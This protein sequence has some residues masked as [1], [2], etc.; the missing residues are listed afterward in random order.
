M[1]W[2]VQKIYAA[3][4]LPFT[5]VTS[6]E[7]LSGE[8][9]AEIRKRI[10]AV[11]KEEAPVT[12]WLLI[13]RVINSFGIY[14]AGA[15]IRPEMEAILAGMKLNVQTDQTGR[16]YWKARQNPATWNEY[17]LFGDYDL[18]C[19]DVQLLPDAEIANAAAAV[20][21]KQ[22]LEYSEL[23]RQTAELL[24]YTRMGS[25]VTAGMKRGIDLALK[26][27]RISKKGR[28]YSI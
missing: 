25:N 7:F 3:A 20:A 27:R 23:A 14:K 16:V 17:R 15:R 1:F 8:L 4:D 22:S 13:K 28:M 9:T 12:E 6:D 19:R 26:T 18:T 5:A 10:Q 2:T 24:G 11:I 21:A